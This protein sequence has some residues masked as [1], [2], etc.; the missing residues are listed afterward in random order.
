[1]KTTLTTF[2][3]VIL[4]LALV[5]S[6]CG[7]GAPAA[8]TEAG[9][10]AAAPVAPSNI[11]IVSEGRVVPAEDVQLSFFT[12]GQVDE[13]LVAEGDS[14]QAGDIVARLG[15]REQ[16]EAQI[17]AAESELVAANQA[18]KALND[19]VS[20]ARAA[21]LQAV[22]AANRAVRD[23]QYQVDI[24]T[25]PTSQQGMTAMEAVVATRA[26]LDEARA[27]FEP[28]KYFSSNNSTRQD[29]KESLDEAQSEYNAAIRRLEYE[30][31]LKNA[32]ADLDQALEDYALYE[33]GPDP[34]DVEAAEARIAAAEAN[35]AA[36]RAA[37]D[38][39]ALQT[40]IS[41]MIVEQDLIVGQ[42]VSPGQPVMRIADFSQMFVETDDLTE[43]EVVDVEVGQ[44]VAII[45]DALPD[46]ELT[47]VV[48]S[49]SQVFE[50][51]RG[52][53]TYTVKIRLDNPDPRLRWGMT[54]EVSFEK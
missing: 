20:T 26:Q 32:Q 23:A 14:V 24:Y 7:G 5:L 42:Q 17:A 6:G 37:L 9:P 30:T 43:I 36:A 34:D 28:Y 12:T 29:L 54:V 11:A 44:T 21:A 47:G 51:K 38:N 40:T 2:S 13:V 33:I 1:M 41:G 39:L 10:T 19:A 35:L 25:I 50:E 45:A 16:I 48:E 4:A 49:I 3:F 8:A 53:I 27:A 31:A 15:N 52:D 46:V 18:L 22:T